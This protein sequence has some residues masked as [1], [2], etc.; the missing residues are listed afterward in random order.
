MTHTYVPEATQSGNYNSFIS[1][2]LSNFEYVSCNSSFCQAILA[3][4]LPKKQYLSSVTE[5]RIC[6]TSA[7]KQDK[8]S[9]SDIV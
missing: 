3:F 8:K 2:C 5:I 1:D 4:P 6:F 7:E 9:M